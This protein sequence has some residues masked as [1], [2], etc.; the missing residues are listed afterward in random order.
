M[1]RMPAFGLR[2]PSPAPAA[3]HAAHR[4][5]PGDRD[6]GRGSDGRKPASRRCQ[7]LQAGERAALSS[8]TTTSS[9]VPVRAPAAGR[10]AGSRRAAIA[11]VMTRVKPSIAA[12]HHHR[13]DL[14]DSSARLEINPARSAAHALVPEPAGRAADAG[15]EQAE[16][17]VALLRVLDRPG[18][19]ARQRP[20]APV[21]FAP[22]PWPGSLEQPSQETR[23]PERDSSAGRRPARPTEARLARC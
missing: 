12:H 8:S 2:A 19:S 1:A 21:R 15:A 6:I 20:A 3:S 10:P 16:L 14:G 17:L 22:A 9:T 7:S 18:A 13:A 5:R 4:R 23:G 11:V